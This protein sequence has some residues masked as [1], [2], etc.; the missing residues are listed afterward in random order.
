MNVVIK[1]SIV[2]RNLNDFQRLIMLVMYRSHL[3][4]VLVGVVWT[5]LV[6]WSET[7]IFFNWL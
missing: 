1:I 2:Y 7:W 5:L 4:V 6:D 3:N